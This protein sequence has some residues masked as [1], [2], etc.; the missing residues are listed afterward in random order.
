MYYKAE[1]SGY[2]GNPGFREAI[3]S[4][5]FEHIKLLFSEILVSAAN[6]DEHQ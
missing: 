6:K 5:N 2:Q 4:R 1:Y 3:S